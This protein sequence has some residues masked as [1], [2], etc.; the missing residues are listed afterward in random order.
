MDK[1]EKESHQAPERAKVAM[2]NFDY[3]VGVSFKSLRVKVKGVA[4]AIGTITVK[5]SN[6][7]DQTFIAY[8][9][10]MK[11]VERDRISFKRRY[12]RC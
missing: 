5:L 10:V 7:K 11:E 1:V 8:D 9:R 12:V 3:T 6:K 4:Q 2:D